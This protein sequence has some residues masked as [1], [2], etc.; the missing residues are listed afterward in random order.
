MASHTNVN[1]PRWSPNPSPPRSPTHATILIKDDV[2]MDSFNFP[3][4]PASSF[5]VNVPRWTPDPSPTRLPSHEP[6]APLGKDNQYMDSFDSEADMS[7]SIEGF[8]PFSTG[9]PVTPPRYPPPQAS[10]KPVRPIYNAPSLKINLDVNSTAEAEMVT[11]PMQEEVQRVTRR[12]VRPGANSVKGNEISLTWKDLWVTASNGS[13]GS[14]A[15]LQGLMGYAQP[16][17]VLAIMGP[18]GCGKSTLLDTLAG[19]HNLNSLLPSFN[20]MIDFFVTQER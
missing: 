9:S 16:G 1:V 10:T 5:N 17:E 14:R 4:E 19:N 18:S 20:Y 2:E 8:F 15:I 6:V 3:D 12:T 11:V 7:H 13:A